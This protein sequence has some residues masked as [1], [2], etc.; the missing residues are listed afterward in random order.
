MSDFLCNLINVLF[1]FNR[2]INGTGALMQ[3]KEYSWCYLQNGLALHLNKL[4]IIYLELHKKNFAGKKMSMYC[5]CLNTERPI[6]EFQ[7]QLN[8]EFGRFLVV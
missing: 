8:S 7:T 6:T 3:G 2:F 5:E 4:L 1:H